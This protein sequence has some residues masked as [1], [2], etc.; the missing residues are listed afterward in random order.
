M[1][2]IQRGLLCPRISQDNAH[3]GEMGYVTISGAGFEYLDNRLA[4]LAD[5][6]RNI[7]RKWSAL[8]EF[9]VDEDRPYRQDGAII[10]DDPDTERLLEHRIRFASYVHRTRDP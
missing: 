6:E 3:R 8:P 5:L 7:Q 9:R 1:R 2:L 10:L 4:F